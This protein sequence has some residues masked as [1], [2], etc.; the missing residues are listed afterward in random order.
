MRRPTELRPDVTSY[1]P[2]RLQLPRDREVVLAARDGA[3]T[4]E[5]VAAGGRAW[6]LESVV[7]VDQPW[8]WA[9]I[10]RTS[11][12]FAWGCRARDWPVAG[13]VGRK[14]AGEGGSR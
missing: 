9:G 2:R 12:R 8:A 14:G 6:L 3:L 4:A 11:Q 13:R 10:G 5:V 7:L 1:R